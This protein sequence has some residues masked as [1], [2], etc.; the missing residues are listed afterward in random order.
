MALV[1]SD[2]GRAYNVPTEVLDRHRLERPREEVSAL[3]G[4]VLVQVY[5]KCDLTEHTAASA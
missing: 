3:G 2:D 4:Q 5:L 1:F